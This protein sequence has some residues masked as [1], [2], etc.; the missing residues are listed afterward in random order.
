[1]DRCKRNR[2]LCHGEYMNKCLCHGKYSSV[3]NSPMAL[4][5][6]Y[7][8]TGYPFRIKIVGHSM[9][10]C[11]HF[12]GQGIKIIKIYKKLCVI[13]VNYGISII[14]L[15]Q[16]Q[17]MVLVWKFFIGQGGVQKISMVYAHTCLSFSSSN[18]P[19]PPP[20]EQA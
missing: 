16:V 7:R 1:M 15:A 18:A 13:R 5:V 14:L 4:E 20:W 9:M 11:I 12:L 10:N 2:C 6:M 8:R 19:P 17:G 3:K